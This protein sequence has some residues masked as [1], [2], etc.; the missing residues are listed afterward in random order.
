MICTCGEFVCGAS[1]YVSFGSKK[2][3]H[4]RCGSK[5]NLS[6]VTS[7]TASP[8]QVSQR[9]QLSHS[10]PEKSLPPQNL[11]IGHKD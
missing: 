5:L 9:K 7:I 1:T 4:K 2:F 11:L 3:K 8:A 10:K 6:P